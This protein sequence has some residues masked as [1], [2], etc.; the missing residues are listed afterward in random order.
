[1]TLLQY[2]NSNTS[3]KGYKN[4]TQTTFMIFIGNLSC[5][6]TSAELHGDTFMSQQSDKVSA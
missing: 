6:R 5:S 1:M 3:F 2:A 4:K